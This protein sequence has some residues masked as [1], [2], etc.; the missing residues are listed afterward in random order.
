MLIAILYFILAL[1]TGDSND[2]VSGSRGT[3]IFNFPIGGSKHIKDLIAKT[4][5]HDVLTPQDLD[6]KISEYY[7]NI[8]KLL[9]K[10]FLQATRGHTIIMAIALNSQHSY[11]PDRFIEEGVAMMEEYCQ[12]MAFPKERTESFIQQVVRSWKELAAQK[13]ELAKKKSKEGT[14]GPS[15][16]NHAAS[17]RSALMQA[18]AILES[19]VDDKDVGE[20][21]ASR[22]EFSEETMAMIDNATF[23]LSEFLLM[24]VELLNHIK[25]HGTSELAKSWASAALTFF[26]RQSEEHVAATKQDKV[27]KGLSSFNPV[28]LLDVCIDAAYKQNSNPTLVLQDNINRVSNMVMLASEKSP[29]D[30]SHR[31]KIENEKLPLER[32][33]NSKDLGTFLIAAVTR[34]PSKWVRQCGEKFEEQLRLGMWKDDVHDLAFVESKLVALMPKEKVV[35]PPIS[36]KKPA[37]ADEDEDGPSAISSGAQQSGKGRSGKG[38]KGGKDGSNGGKGKG[39]RGSGGGGRGKGGGTGKGSGTGSKG[40]GGGGHSQTTRT[41]FICNQPG[42]GYRDV[43]SDGT[44]YHSSQEISS[45]REK[46]SARGNNTSGST[47]GGCLAAIWGGG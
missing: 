19:D 14:G 8:T 25:K 9:P 11:L 4:A 29:T 24:K 41:C 47:G 15:T 2:G 22:A 36:P 44:P 34:S 5:I 18:A 43:R 1:F 16:A 13:A 31:L 20:K 17:A 42:H 3:T 21:L 30:V 10:S 32:Q 37:A 35:L 7:V 27:E 26:Q 33:F 45:A 6:S 28:R 12:S 46:Q 38:S 23:H 40:G 39:N